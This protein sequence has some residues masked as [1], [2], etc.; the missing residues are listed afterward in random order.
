MHGNGKIKPSVSKT[1]LDETSPT[2]FPSLF[3][4]GLPELPWSIAA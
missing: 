1:M 2:R 4:S 3:M